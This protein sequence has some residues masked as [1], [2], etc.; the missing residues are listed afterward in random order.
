MAKEQSLLTFQ[1]TRQWIYRS[2]ATPVPCSICRQL[3]PINQLYG[4]YFEIGIGKKSTP[5]VPPPNVWTA[6]K[7]CGAT[8]DPGKVTFEEY[9]L[10][11]CTYLYCVDCLKKNDRMK[12]PVCPD[13]WV[14]KDWGGCG[15]CHFP[16]CK[17]E[18]CTPELSCQDCRCVDGYC[19]EHLSFLSCPQC[20]TKEAVMQRA[21]FRSPL[22]QNETKET[23]F[24][25]CPDHVIFCGECRHSILCSDCPGLT[26]SEF[27]F[28]K[29][30]TEIRKW[31]KE[32]QP[33]LSL[34][35]TACET[36]KRVEQE[37]IMKTYLKQRKQLYPFG[38]F[39]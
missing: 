39:K 31:K 12:C 37:Q 24:I 3:S 29:E 21:T 10:R 38:V 5:F 25:H 35:C 32:K 28:Y 7:Q 9:F 36:K 22:R 15:T 8:I 26:A 2:I 14:M 1:C 11:R 19:C 4:H 27:R 30:T 18:T 13:N 34:V 20:D 6:L 33:L 23:P 17:R 16:G